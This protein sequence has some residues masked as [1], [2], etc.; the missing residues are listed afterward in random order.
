MTTTTDS[1]ISTASGSEEPAV[2]VEGLWK[3]FGPKAAKI[4]AGEDSKLSRK[5]LQEKTGP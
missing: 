4:M 5:E 1:P 3:I 2:H